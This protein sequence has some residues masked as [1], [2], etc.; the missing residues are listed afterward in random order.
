MKQLIALLLLFPAW[1][2]PPILIEYR[3]KPPYSFTNNGKPSGFLLER[4]VSIFRQAG[5]LVDF[6]E[7]PVKRII[8]DIKTDRLP[9]CSPGWYKLPEREEFARF[10]LPIHQDRPHVVLAGPDS[11]AAIRAKQTLKALLADSA[12]VMGVVDGVSYGPEIDGWIA[13]LPNKPMRVTVTPLQLAKMIASRRAD[14]MM[15]DQ[16]D[17]EVMN[18]DHEADALGMQRIDFPDPPQG[19]KRYIMCSKSVEPAVIEKMNA[20]I[21][22]LGL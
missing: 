12:F 14:F 8:F 20:A 17:L 4:T 15:I 3:D 1:A 10:S 7:V 19:L 22:T 9:A 21:T 18:K 13:S 5:I 2:A 16:D 6:E 11:A